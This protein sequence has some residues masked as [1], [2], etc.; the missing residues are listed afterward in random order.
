[1]DIRNKP[2]R[3]NEGFTLIELVVVMVVAGV[4]A[5][6]TIPML[7]QFVRASRVDAAATD[8]SQSLW[9]AR[10]AAIR[11]AAP[12]VMCISPNGQS[13]S[14]GMLES[15]GSAAWRQG[16]VSFVDLNKDGNLA[17]STSLQFGQPA[18]ATTTDLLIAHTPP[19]PDSVRIR[20]YLN[21]TLSN[22]TQISFLPSGRAGAPVQAETPG[23]NATAYFRIDP[24]DGSGSPYC[25]GGTSRIV[26]LTQTGRA[27][28]ST[29]RCT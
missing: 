10:D 1:M 26:T 11:S 20:F 4:I 24:V 28:I 18:V 13:C 17:V 23:S 19:K 3:K 12:V 6:F 22:R 16:W 15:D 25:V 9:T 29:D 21:N 8:L 2:I 5:F 14:A 7:S 27:Q